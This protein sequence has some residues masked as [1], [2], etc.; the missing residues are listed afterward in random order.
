MDQGICLTEGRNGLS[1]AK[2]V[3]QGHALSARMSWS[4][5]RR[6]QHSGQEATKAVRDEPR[7]P[8]HTAEENKDFILHA[9]MSH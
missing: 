1:K 7:T 9:I 6:K 5:K 4:R 8:R 3:C 2:E